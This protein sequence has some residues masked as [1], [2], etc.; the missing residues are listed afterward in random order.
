MVGGVVVELTAATLPE[1]ESAPAAL[2]DWRRA[3]LNIVTVFY[4]I[5]TKKDQLLFCN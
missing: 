3:F 4:V 2:V 5:Y 1:A